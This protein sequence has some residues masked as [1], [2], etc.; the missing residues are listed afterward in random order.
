MERHNLVVDGIDFVA[1]VVAAVESVDAVVKLDVAPIALAVVVAV[2]E[3]PTTV[4][5]VAAETV[6]ALAVAEWRR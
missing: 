6:V 5:V 3:V 4:L 2:V 1:I